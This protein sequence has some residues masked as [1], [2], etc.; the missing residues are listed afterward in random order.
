MTLGVVVLLHCSLLLQ[1]DYFIVVEKIQCFMYV[2]MCLFLAHIP[3]NSA[4]CR[5]F[6]HVIM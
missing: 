1:F 3:A 5:L 6:L 2:C 4:R